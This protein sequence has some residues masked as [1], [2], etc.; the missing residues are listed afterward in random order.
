MVSE[1]T[2]EG[3]GTTG[4]LLQ[5]LFGSILK[6]A[7]PTSMDQ[8]F[9]RRAP[10]PE[11]SDASTSTQQQQSW[12]QSQAQDQQFSPSPSPSQSPPPPLST[13]SSDAETG[14]AVTMAAGGCAY[15]HLSSAA[16]PLGLLEATEK[17][18]ESLIEQLGGDDDRHHPRS[19]QQPLGAQEASPA[20]SSP[21]NASWA[22]ETAKTKLTQYLPEPGFF[23][24][25][26]LAGGISRTATAPLDRLKVYLLVNTTS[27]HVAIDA[28]KQGQPLK[29]LRKAGHPFGDAVRSLYRQGGFRNFFAGKI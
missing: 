4:F 7:Q 25:G 16:H 1:E 20:H 2:L 26:A 5:A 22:R 28:A 27:A 21:H 15:D 10:I 18:V 11:S 6:L 8:T 23:V 13:T 14:P 19:Q 29:A 9:Y 12:A 24:A 3:L 17:G